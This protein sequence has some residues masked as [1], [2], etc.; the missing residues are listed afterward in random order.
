MSSPVPIPPTCSRGS[1]TSPAS[2]SRSTTRTRPYYQCRPSGPEAERFGGW[3]RILQTPAAIAILNDDLTY[4]VIHMD[5]RELEAEPRAKLDGILGGALGR[6]HAGRGQCRIQRQ[7]VDEPLR[8]LA[9]G[10]AADDGTLPAP[11]T[12][13]TCRWR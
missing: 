6:R 3:K 13:A 7:D 10:G 8:G 2:I 12:S 4:R 11:P 5:G 1:S 9:Y